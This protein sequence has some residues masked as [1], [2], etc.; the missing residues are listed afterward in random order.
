MSKTDQFAIPLFA[1]VDKSKVDLS[2]PL[3]ESLGEQLA[4]YLEGQFG[5]KSLSSRLL[6]FK[7]DPF[8][9]LHDVSSECLPQLCSLVDVQ[10]T[11]LFR[12]ERTDESTVTLVP[13]NVKID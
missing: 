10:R 2:Q 4:L 5:I 7:E 3:P 12:Y 1:L 8:L 11:Q 9:V 13:L 6:L